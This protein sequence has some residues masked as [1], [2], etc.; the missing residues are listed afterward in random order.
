ME[1]SYNQV[2]KMAKLSNQEKAIY[3]AAIGAVASH[4]SGQSALSGALTAG[5]SKL[6]TETILKVAGKNTALAQWLIAGFGYAVS[7]TT[8]GAGQTGAAIGSSGM[9]N[10]VLSEEQKEE[11]LE[12]IKEKVD[13]EGSNAGVQEYWELDKLE[14]N[15]KI[16]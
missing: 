14:K 2:G 6:I 13:K 15:N 1:L 3:H 7:K 11:G 10:N 9:K 8:G 12:N 16:N 4:L 5:T